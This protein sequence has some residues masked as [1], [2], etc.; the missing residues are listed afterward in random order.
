[1][2]F[3]FAQVFLFCYCIYF[4]LLV[5]QFYPQKAEKRTPSTAKTKDEET[6]THDNAKR[7]N[8]RRKSNEGKPPNTETPQKT[9][10]SPSGKA[11]AEKAEKPQPQPTGENRN[12]RKPKAKTAKRR[13]QPKTAE[14]KAPTPK[15]S[16]TKSN[17]GRA[18]SKQ[19]SKSRNAEKRKGRAKG[20]KQ[21]RKKSRKTQQHRKH[22]QK[23]EKQ[24]RQRPK[25]AGRKNQK[26]RERQARRAPPQSRKKARF[27]PFKPFFLG[28]VWGR[29][30][31]THAPPRDPPEIKLPERWNYNRRERLGGRKF[32]L[33]CLACYNGKTRAR[34]VWCVTSPFIP[35]PF[36]ILR[37]CKKK[38]TGIN[39]VNFVVKILFVCAI[40]QYLIQ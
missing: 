27:L 33:A 26:A 13:R 11:R 36:F 10:K 16:P 1:M 24:K 25:R 5:A 6:T 2:L 32:G 23:A 22:P 37:Y 40:V 21:K 38:Y 35:S 12:T 14:E 7:R 18:K 19:K 8:P 3:W 9:P 28:G 15:S 20:K 34:A 39:P 30:R 4:P 29:E 17:A 31:T